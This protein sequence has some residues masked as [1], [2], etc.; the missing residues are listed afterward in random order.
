MTSFHHLIKNWQRYN[1][2]NKLTS[3]TTSHLGR[4]SQANNLVPISLMK[5]ILILK[6]KQIKLTKTKIDQLNRFHREATESYLKRLSLGG[7]LLSWW[8]KESMKESLRLCLLQVFL[9]KKMILVWD[10]HVGPLLRQKLNE[11]WWV[12]IWNF[13]VQISMTTS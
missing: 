4:K 7:L 6:S 5:Y 12:R 3:M 13:L 11:L 10:S 1:R 9:E 2:L 8:I